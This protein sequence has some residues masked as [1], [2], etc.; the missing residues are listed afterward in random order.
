MTSFDE[1]EKLV[2]EVTTLLD[3][4]ARQVKNLGLDPETNIRRIGEA[5][6]L[7]SEIRAAVYAVRPDLTACDAECSRLEPDERM[8]GELRATRPKA[9]MPIRLAPDCL[10]VEQIT[11]LCT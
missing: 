10:F 2:D 6:V 1:L 3:G 4:A 9:D 5:I 7:V 8:A 11:R